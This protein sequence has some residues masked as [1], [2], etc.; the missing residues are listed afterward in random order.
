MGSIKNETLF[1]VVK[2]SP[3]SEVLFAGY[4]RSEFLVVDTFR[5]MEA[6]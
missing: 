6:K 4:N 1:Y 2:Y 5:L 3:S